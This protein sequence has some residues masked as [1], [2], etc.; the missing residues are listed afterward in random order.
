MQV[1]FA[2]NIPVAV[3]YA[4]VNVSTLITGTGASVT[5]LISAT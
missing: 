2:T 1:L 4:R 3:R 5:A